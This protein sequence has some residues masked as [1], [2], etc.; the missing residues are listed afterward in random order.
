MEDFTNNFTIQDEPFARYFL[1]CRET[2][3]ELRTAWGLYGAAK[4]M[5]IQIDPETG[6]P[7]ACV[8]NMNI[9]ITFGTGIYCN[10][11]GLEIFAERNPG[12]KAEEYRFLNEKMLPYAV[13][14]RIQDTFTEEE[15]KLTENKSAWGGTWA[16]HAVPD[17]IGIAKDG[18]DAYREKIA[19]YAQLNPDKTDFYKAMNVTLDAFD[20]LSKRFSMLAEDMAKNAEGKSKQRLN[21]TAKCFKNA[22]K[23]PAR[24]FYEATIVYLMIFTLDGIDSPGHFDQ[25]M[26]DFYRKTETEDRLEILSDL[27][28]FFHDRRVWNL[29]ISGSDENGNDLT[30]EL[31]YDILD[32]VI[33][34]KYNTPNL[35]MRC[36]KG[37]PRKLLEKAAE[38]LATGAGI[39]ALYNDEVVC[40]AL[41][42]IGIPPHDS[43]LYVMNGCN[44]IDIQGKSHMGLEDGEVN[45]AKALEYTLHNGRCSVFNEIRSIQSGNPETFATFDEFYDAFLKQMYH[46]A[47]KSCELSNKGQKLLAENSRQ[48]IRSLTIEG[49]LEKGLDYKNG[50]PLYGHGQ[51]LVEGIADAV[52]SLAAV[53]KFV[54]DEKK[55]SMHDLVAALEADYEGY[56]Y[57]F[58]LLKNSEEK[59]GN[60][61]DEVDTIASDVIDK[62][63]TYLQTIPTVRGGFF[64]GGCSPYNRAAENGRLTGALPNGRKRRELLFADSIGAEPGKDKTGPTAALNSCLKY[65]QKKATSGFV[66]NIKFDKKMF[67]AKKGQEAFLDLVKTYFENG[68]QQIS[69]NVL[70]REELLDAKIHPENH[71]N[72][73]VR[74]G[75]YSDYFNNLS[76][77]LQDNIIQRTMFEI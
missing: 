4:E 24:D 77:G 42:A 70:S 1:N 63:F 19:K 10:T 23:K 38:A 75:G 60:D 28:E 26:L 11:P 37:T 43:H 5:P 39:P 18:T 54:Y 52:D 48:P 13:V 46:L 47:K 22:T 57:L 15:K 33:K 6:F 49:C 44:Q 17:L 32:M 20:I 62:L 71:Q 41:E 36:H 76:P 3:L 40:P 16:G 64:G 14:P 27:W 58:I 67:A 25:Y 31:S 69:V 50:G 21:R 56:E 8:F 2:D 61:I 51:I 55:I 68:G 29:C 9:G 59:F 72:L 35:T 45:I 34:T 12:R 65:N 73:I 66:L 53:K 7:D 74:V 30:N